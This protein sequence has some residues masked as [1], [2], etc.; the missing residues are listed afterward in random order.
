MRL[1]TVCAVVGV[2]LCA[3]GLAPSERVTAKTHTVTIENM[4]FQPEALT[5]ARGD[6]IAWVNRDL[7]PHTATSQAGGFDSQRIQAGESWTF[8]VRTKG[9]FAYLCT[10]HPTMKAV[11]R[12]Q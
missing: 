1:A 11:L 5:V 6:T 3:V 12:V 8:T 9:D 7:V 4:R 10:Y 2:I